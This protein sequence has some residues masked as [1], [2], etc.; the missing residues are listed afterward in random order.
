M[1][2]WGGGHF[3]MPHMVTVDKQGNLWTT[4]VA[5]HTVVKWSAAG[6]KLL[7]LGVHMEPG[8]DEGHFCKPTQARCTAPAAAV[9]AHALPSR[10]G[11][12]HAVGSRCWQ[13]AFLLLQ[14]KE[15]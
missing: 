6:K 1:A 5:S 10:A 15:M 3:M 8:H 7:E 2:Q 9:C 13:Y 12:S 4:D 14:I 11:M